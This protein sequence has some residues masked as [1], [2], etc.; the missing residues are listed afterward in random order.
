MK[1]LPRMSEIC[2]KIRLK[3]SRRWQLQVKCLKKN[4]NNKVFQLHFNFTFKKVKKPRK[5]HRKNAKMRN[6]SLFVTQ[7][8]HYGA[9]IT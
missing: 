9:A 4:K 3:E 7:D 8:R 5:P 1:R 6:L 2:G